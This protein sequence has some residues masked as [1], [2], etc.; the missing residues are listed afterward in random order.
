MKFR[1][2]ALSVIDK[3]KEQSRNM[4]AVYRVGGVAGVSTALMMVPTMTSF[5]SEAGG[6]SNLLSAEVLS[7][8]TNGFSSMVITA[9]AVIVMGI[10]AGV[11][12]IGL[13]S[14]AKY[15]LKQLKGVLSK[16]G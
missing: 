14:A 3:A 7:A 8:I 16:A 12:I 1:N 5:A 13:S 2:Y 11:S 10:T 9:T 15:A 4:Q 6:G